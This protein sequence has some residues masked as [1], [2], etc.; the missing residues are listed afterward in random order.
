MGDI[1]ARQLPVLASTTSNM[2]YDLLPASD[3]C[4]LP[5]VDIGESGR[6]RYVV[7]SITITLYNKSLP[8]YIEH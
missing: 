7:T 2:S 4:S 8:S 6:S 3:C 5:S 1:L